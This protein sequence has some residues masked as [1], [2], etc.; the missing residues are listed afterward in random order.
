MIGPLIDEKG[1]AKVEDH[2]ARTLAASRSQRAESACD[3]SGSP[4]TM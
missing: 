1:V 4:C 2:I 3:A